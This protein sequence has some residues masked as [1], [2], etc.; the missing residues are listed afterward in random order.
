MQSEKAESPSTMYTIGLTSKAEL[1][2]A[3]DEGGLGH[4]RR[5]EIKS[6]VIANDRFKYSFPTAPSMELRYVSGLQH[7][8]N[9]SCACTCIGCYNGTHCGSEA[10]RGG[11]EY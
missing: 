7:L 6:R 11:P 9:W 8:A 4:Y 10:C 5:T 2:W 3:C 1:T